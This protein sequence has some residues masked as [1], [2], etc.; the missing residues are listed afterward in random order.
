MTPDEYFA[1]EAE[2]V[3][4]HEYYDGEVFSMAG[5]SDRHAGITVNVTIA[6]TLGLRPRGCEPYSGDMREQ[7]LASSRYV[8][9]DF[10]T[11]CGEPE[12]VD[13]RRVTLLNPTVVVEVLSPSTADF[14]RGTKAL[15][16]RALPSLQALVLVAQD[17][18]TVIVYRREAA[19][20]ITEDVTCLDATIEILGERLA[21]SD[22]YAGVTLDEEPTGR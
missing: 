17:A 2:Q 21:L 11:V 22:L 1:W 14:D 5:G 15:W 4:K 3:V 13:D 9:P 16:Y 20:W 12:F 19:H 6:F 10:S 18:S 7:M 8:Y